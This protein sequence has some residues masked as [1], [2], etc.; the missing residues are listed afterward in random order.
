M[1]EHVTTML[2]KALARC[3]ATERNLKMIETC[4][5]TA[6]ILE[7][8][9]KKYEDDLM[10]ATSRDNMNTM[11]D[12]AKSLRETANSMSLP[13]SSIRIAIADIQEAL[14]CLEG[15][16]REGKSDKIKEYAEECDIPLDER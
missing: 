11:I 16:P 10:P 2:E 5:N 1:S 9:T 8:C 15:N 7:A 14:V 4:R 6:S 3:R 12:A 13:V